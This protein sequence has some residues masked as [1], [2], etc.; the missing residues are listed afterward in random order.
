MTQFFSISVSLLYHSEKQKTLYKPRKYNFSEVSCLPLC[1]ETDMTFHSLIKAVRY[2]VSSYRR[3]SEV[4]SRLEESSKHFADLAKIK[5]I[6]VQNLVTA[7]REPDFYVG[8]NLN[9]QLSEIIL[10]SFEIDNDVLELLSSFSSETK[11]FPLLLENILHPVLEEIKN[12]VKSTSTILFSM[13]SIVP[14]QYFTS[15]AELARIFILHS[16]PPNKQNGRAYEETLLGTILQKSCLPAAESDHW[17]YFH[18]PSG[19]YIQ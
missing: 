15:S 8:Q 14:L 9:K 1:F 11:Q 3:A 17:D 4:S 5:E 6:I 18:Q 10:G 2:L 13:N 7:F 19:M 12:N 16:F